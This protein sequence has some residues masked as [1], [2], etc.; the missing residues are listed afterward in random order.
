[1]NKWYEF[2]GPI[3]IE[4]IGHLALT[5]KHPSRIMESWVLEF[6]V[7]GKR[8]VR[9]ESLKLT[10]VSGE[11]FLLPPHIPHYGIEI[12]SHDIYYFHFKIVGNEVPRPDELN[13]SSMILPILFE[14]PKEP[15]II[16]LFSFL[17]NNYK[18]KYIDPVFFEPHLIS[19]LYYL[20]FFAQ[21]SYIWNRPHEILA[22][23]IMTFIIDNHKQDLTYIDLEKH[24]NMSYKHLNNIFMEKYYRPVVR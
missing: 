11:F 1:M 8:T 19:I 5:N 16:G 2:W 15:D 18:Y 4:E 6:V 3:Q 20:S 7:A 24:F 9:I 14:Y 10:A 21:K 23:K 22:D 13:T 17:Y 12:D